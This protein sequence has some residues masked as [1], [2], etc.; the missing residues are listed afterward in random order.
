MKL[1]PGLFLDALGTQLEGD[2]EETGRTTPMS[3]KCPLHGGDGRLFVYQDPSGGF[4]FRCEDPS[5]HFRGDAIALVAAKYGISVKAAVGMLRSDG[6]LSRC[7]M[8]PMSAAEADELCDRAATQAKIRAYLSKCSQQL[9]RNPTKSRIRAG[10]DVSTYHLI[11]PEIGLLVISDDMPDAFS[12]YKKKKYR[13]ST[14]LTFPYTYNGDV[15]HVR[16]FDVQTHSEIDDIVVVRPDLGVFC[17]DSVLDGSSEPVSAVS[18]PVAMSVYYGTLRKS[19]LN[20]PRLVS[21]SGFPLPNSFDGISTLNMLEFSDSKVSLDFLLEPLGNNDVVEGAVRQPNIRFYRRAGQALDASPDLYERAA[22]FYRHGDEDGMTALEVL[23]SR[24]SELADLGKSDQIEEALRKHPLSCENREHLLEF[25]SNGGLNDECRR[26]LCDTSADGL[27]KLVLG[28]R[29]TLVT[30][31]TALYV[32]KSNLE[33][34][35]LANFGIR[36]SNRT[37]GYD[38]IDYLECSVTPEDKTIAPVDIRIPESAWSSAQRMRRL[39]SMAFSAKSEAPYIA[40]YQQAGIDWYDV[41]LKLAEG[42]AVRREIVNLGVDEMH[43][44]QF[45]LVSV[46]PRTKTIKQQNDLLNVPECVYSRYSSVGTRLSTDAATPLRVLMDRSDGMQS[47]ALL[48]GL[49][50]TVYRIACLSKREKHPSHGG[51]H[52][53]FVETEENC[54]DDT[55]SAINELFT[56]DPVVDISPGAP[57]KSLSRFR[58]LGSLPLVCR[59]PRVENIQ[60]LLSVLDE[61][62]FP[63]IA[64]V[65]SYTASLLNGRIRAEYVTPSNEHPSSLQVQDTLLRA[66]SAAIPQIVLD[67]CTGETQD[68]ANARAPSS[69]LGYRML[70][71]M[72]GRPDTGCVKNLVSLVFAGAGMSGVDSFFEKLHFGVTG[73]SGKF[74]LCIVNGAPQPG[75]S[76]TRRGQHIFVMDDVVLIGKYAVDLVNKFSTNV[77]SIAQLD[78]ELREREFLVAPPEELDF[79]TSRCWCLPREVYEDRILGKPLILDKIT[80]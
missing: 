35:P 80:Q 62:E 4:L 76:F 52:L 22:G 5:C 78:A 70:C 2:P 79:D 65:D 32:E 53:F 54:F 13:K 1:D 31:P 29:K 43:D 18:D 51:R 68:D 57:V 24:M 21:I 50:Y 20:R 15:M 48:A 75:Y 63:V 66:L 47:A 49:G 16:I 10:L 61:V 12:E 77:Y 28:N 30:D 42:C 44:V 73:I 3:C 59:I 34:M 9:A 19:M 40:M 74:R 56:D 39:I 11:P 64:T 17:E 23:A 25:I 46:E 27:K 6:V 45:P 71:R 67:A 38:G 58:Q 69:V 8:E 36:V 72:A 37:R 41:M 26:L 33:R 55:L 60:R 7:L 14:L